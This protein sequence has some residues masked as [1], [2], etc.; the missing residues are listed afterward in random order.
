[1]CAASSPE[2]DQEPLQDKTPSSLACFLFIFHRKPNQWLAAEINAGP[3]INGLQGKVRQETIKH[4][5]KGGA[6]SYF[7]CPFNQSIEYTTV[8]GCNLSPF[9]LIW[10]DKDGG[11]P[12]APE[13]VP[14]PLIV[15]SSH[16]SSTGKILRKSRF[17]VYNIWV[18]VKT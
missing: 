1:M 13:W 2:L 17:L 5:M 6:K 7:F 14:F 18:W 16:G 3:Y 10:F 11:C 15:D 12:R 4:P 9:C 8:L